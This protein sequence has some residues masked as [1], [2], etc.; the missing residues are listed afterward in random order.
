[1]P[2]SNSMVRVP[3]VQDVVMPAAAPGDL[4]HYH[5]LPLP[6]ADLPTITGA[7]APTPAPAQRQVTAAPPAT[8]AEQRSD[9]WYNLQQAA[10]ASPNLGQT[11]AA[12]LGQTCTGIGQ[13][14]AAA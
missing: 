11:V 4:C 6:L 2:R 9:S 7:A 5:Q 14:V 3:T 13:T 8:L 10:A 1:M 12:S